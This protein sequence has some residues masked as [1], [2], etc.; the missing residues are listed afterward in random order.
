MNELVDGSLIAVK[1]EHDRL[2]YCEEFREGGVIKP[3]RVHI[4]GGNTGHFVAMEHPAE[5]ARLLTG[6]LLG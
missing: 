3:V 4:W 2:I 1:S 6:F 5:F